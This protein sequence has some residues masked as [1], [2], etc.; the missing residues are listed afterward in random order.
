[1]Y[2]HG[3]AFI[4]ATLL[5]RLKS[6]GLLFISGQEQVPVASYVMGHFLTLPSMHSKVSYL[7]NAGLLIQ[8]VTRDEEGLYTV[9]V[10][11][12]Q[13]GLSLSDTK[14]VHLEVSGRQEQATQI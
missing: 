9:V 3:K 11:F 2:T 4:T 14:T 8:N 13:H 10:N 7:P 12:E 5:Y 6:S 1:M